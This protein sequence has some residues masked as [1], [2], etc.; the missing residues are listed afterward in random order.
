MK[1]KILLNKPTIVADYREKTI[2][3]IL[4]NYRGINVIEDNLSVDFIIGDIGIERKTY[5]DFLNST[6]DKRIFEQ[7]ENQKNF[8]KFVLLLEGLK[9]NEEEKNIFYG[10]LSK[11]IATTNIS[12]IFTENVYDT[13]NMLVKLCEKYGTTFFVL[14][15][16]KIRRKES[17]IEKAVISVLISFPGISHRTASKILENFKSIKNF[18]NAEKHKLNRVLGEKKAEKIYKIINHE[19]K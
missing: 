3:D 8:N 14:P 7:V 16:S 4:K 2:I 10:I 12:V 6:F 13:A 15:R 19:F 5:E 17:K 1:Q 18:I 9:I 11:I